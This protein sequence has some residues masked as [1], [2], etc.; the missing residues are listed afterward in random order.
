MN[1]TACILLNNALLSQTYSQQHSSDNNQT[2]QS[3]LF[4]IKKTVKPSL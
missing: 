4:F 1:F 2:N 3:D